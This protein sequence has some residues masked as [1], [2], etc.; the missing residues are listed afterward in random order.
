MV[1]AAEVEGRW[2]TVTA[3]I[4][5][6]GESSRLEEALERYL[7]VHCFRV[8]ALVQATGLWHW[9][10]GPFS[11]QGHEGSAFFCKPR[12]SSLLGFARFQERVRLF[13]VVS[14]KRSV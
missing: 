2:N 11:P 9:L 10:R 8:V 12:Q 13:S 6:N 1:L 14:K 3:I 5:R 7:G 4:H